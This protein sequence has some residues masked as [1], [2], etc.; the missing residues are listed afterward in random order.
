[1]E[2]I[3]SGLIKRSAMYIR[4]DPYANAFRIDDSYV[5]SAK[6]RAM[7]RHD[8]ISTWNYELDSG[9]YFIRL[10]YF[11]WKESLQPDVLEQ[12]AVQEAVEIMVDLWI[13]EQHHEL[14]EYPT[15]PLFDCKNCN[16]PYR[17]PGLP[18]DGKGA[19]T[20]PE[21]GLIWTGK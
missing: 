18:R 8:L 2:R 17:Y 4:H 7:G 3:V 14:D 19:P 16:K 6:Q 11:Y 20:N 13:S 12:Q 21:S 10:L 5:F 1:M 15:G 9:C